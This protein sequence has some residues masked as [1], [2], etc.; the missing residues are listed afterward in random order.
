MSDLPFVLDR[1]A[2]EERLGGELSFAVRHGTPLGVLLILPEELRAG[3]ARRQRELVERLSAMVR[4][5]DV[6]A[7]FD[8]RTL[9]VVVRGIAPPAMRQ[10]AE[11]LCA[12]L[13]SRPP[14][15][16]KGG[17]LPVSIGL[18]VAEPLREEESG[19]ALLA[20][21][22]VALERARSAGGGRVKA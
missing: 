5:E 15:P 2:L 3:D 22:R 21:A 9:A 7:R 12:L 19:E 10:M 14:K 20:R 17:R 11:R 18:A 13:F 8:N 1:V 4:A 16:L 6:I